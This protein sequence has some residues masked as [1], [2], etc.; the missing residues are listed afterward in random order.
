MR[1]ISIDFTRYRS[2]ASANRRDRV[3]TLMLGDAM[4]TKMLGCRLNEDWYA[5]AEALFEKSGQTYMSDWLRPIVQ[6]GVVD[7]EARAL[8]G[9]NGVSTA[10]ID[11]QLAA[12]QARMEGLEE[13]IASQRERLTESQAH[14]L[15]LK[16]ENDGLHRH[17]EASNSNIERITLMLPA[18]KE[19]SDGRGQWWRFWGG[20]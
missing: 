15:D 14:I 13:L 16:N 18:A 12:A 10:P 20:R 9:E 1:L 7:A 3:T 17:L 4:A 11:V 6:A 19:A 2:L 5:R 8:S